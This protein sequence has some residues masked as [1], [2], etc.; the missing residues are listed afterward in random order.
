MK[1]IALQ[2]SPRVDGNTTKLLNAMFNGHQIDVVHVVETGIKPYEYTGFPGRR[3]RCSRWASGWRRPTSSCF[4]TP[5]FW[6]AMSAQ[7]KAFFDRFHR[8]DV[9]S[10]RRSV[11]SSAGE[12]AL[13][14]LQRRPRPSCP[15][16]FEV[17]FPPH[18]PIHRHR[19][20]R[21]LLRH[22]PTPTAS[23]SRPRSSKLPTTSANRSWPAASERRPPYGHSSWAGLLSFLRPLAPFL[24]Q[25]DRKQPQR[26]AKRRKNAIRKEWD[27]G[28]L[29]GSVV[30]GTPKLIKRSVL[31][32]ACAQVAQQLGRRGSSAKIAL[33]AFTSTISLRSNEQ[34]GS[35]VR[36]ESCRLRQRRSAGNCCSTSIASLPQPMGP[37]R[38]S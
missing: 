32:A 20:P 5:V 21:R 24:R 22:G 38:F 28:V 1:V 35:V 14:R 25:K 19:L 9:S 34:V 13:P 33:Q 6:Y 23:A 3:P 17:P 12:W 36:R 4:A 10:A 37:V 15:R 2:G 8:P 16:A 18:L 31:N 27:K 29:C 7:L 26:S 30:F 11:R